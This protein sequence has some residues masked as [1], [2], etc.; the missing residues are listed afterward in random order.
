MRGSGNLLRELDLQGGGDLAGDEL[1]EVRAGPRGLGQAFGE[2]CEK[3]LV[4]EERLP[5]PAGERPGEVGVLLERGGELP[6]KVRWQVLVQRR[7]EDA[8]QALD[9]DQ[10]RIL[11]RNQQV[12]LA[13][14]FQEQLPGRRRVHEPLEARARFDGLAGG[15]DRGGGKKPSSAWEKVAISAV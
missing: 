14:F 12:E 7:T 6:R 13:G 9:E 8:F 11:I 5:Y 10:D 4:L 2:G 3:G 15:S 1:G